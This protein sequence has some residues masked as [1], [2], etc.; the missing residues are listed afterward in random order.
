VNE[1]SNVEVNRMNSNDEILSSERDPI[2]KRT[3][4]RRKEETSLDTVGAFLI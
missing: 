3:D 1:A 4:E 2:P